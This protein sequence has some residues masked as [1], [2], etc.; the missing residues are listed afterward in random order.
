MVKSKDIDSRCS[1]CIYCIDLFIKK[2][3]G[4]LMEQNRVYVNCAKRGITKAQ[5][6]MRDSKA[7]KC[8]DY[9]LKGP[10]WELDM[11]LMKWTLKE[12]N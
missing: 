7:S 5:P 2:E 1:N 10:V 6:N 12:D 8:K 11:K 3:Q 9:D 4:P